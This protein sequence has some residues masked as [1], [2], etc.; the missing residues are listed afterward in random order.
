MRT[1]VVTRNGVV[2]GRR[3][4][5]QKLVA[6]VVLA[7]F[8]PWLFWD[9]KRRKWTH[10]CIAAYVRVARDH[11]H[12]WH[13]SEDAARRE[14]KRVARLHPYYTAAIVKRVEVVGEDAWPHLAQP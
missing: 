13:L 1:L 14:L 3:K 5:S 4:T 11:V 9:A 7:D 2:I 8:V 10:E 6:A 12:S